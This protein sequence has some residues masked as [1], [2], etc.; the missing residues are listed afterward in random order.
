MPPRH[1]RPAAGAKAG[2][3]AL[4]AKPA[5][6]QRA[7]GA[8]Q[9]RGSMSAPLDDDSDL[10]DDDDDGDDGAGGGAGGGG[11]RGGGGGGGGDDDGLSGGDDADF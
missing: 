10:D 5:L 11:G 7:A 9:V 4:G 6:L 2:G 3:A 8:A 1:G